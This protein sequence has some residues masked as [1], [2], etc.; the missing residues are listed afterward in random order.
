[1]RSPT[2][3]IG[4][5]LPRLCLPRQLVV[6]PQRDRHPYGR[7]LPDFHDSC[8]CVL[9]SFTVHGSSLPSSVALCRKCS[10]VTG[11]SNIIGYAL[12]TL[13]GKAGL[14]G[15]QW[16]KSTLFYFFLMSLLLRLDIF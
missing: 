1:M 12:S 5:L 11:F 13:S 3:R 10:T 2:D 6:R 8:W 9:S 7:L 4:T 15:W 14:L 16:S